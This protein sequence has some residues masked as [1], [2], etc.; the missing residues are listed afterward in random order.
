V[1]HVQLVSKIARTIGRFLGLNEDLIE[2]VALGHDI[3]HTPF[4]HDGE[5]FL[6]RICEAHGI[7]SFQHNLQSVH[8]L[9]RVERKG[10]GWNLCLQ[11]LDGILSHDGEVHDE[12]LQPD[13][14]KDFDKLDREMLAKRNNPDLALRPMSLEGCVVRMADTISYI[15]RDIED[16]IR[17]DLVSRSDLPAEA[18]AVLGKTNGTIV[19]N[20]VTDVIHNSYRQPYLAFSRE[21]SQALKTLKDFNL[22]RIYRNPAIKRHT[23]KIEQL[24]VL[25]FNRYMK[26]LQTANKASVI[27]EGYL[28]DMDQRYMDEHQPAEI[29]RDFIAGMTDHYFLQQC[30]PALRPAVEIR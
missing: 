19:Y 1:L 21:V 10:R 11:T 7:G 22:E 18:V 5:R 28:S 30:P 20:L 8:F 9:E 25:L 16:A 24:F 29:V 15:G 2:A 13:R 27:F 3:G 12:R 6:S 14:N 26:D 17:L 4:G 23:L